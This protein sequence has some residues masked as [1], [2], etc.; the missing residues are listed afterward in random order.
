MSP[1]LLLGSVTR[2]TI[3][4]SNAAGTADTGTSFMADV[5]ALVLTPKAA[6]FLEI[7]F[8][9]KAWTLVESLNFCALH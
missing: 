5:F 7:I 8:E 4:P 6:N 3:I 1:L 2:S 9:K